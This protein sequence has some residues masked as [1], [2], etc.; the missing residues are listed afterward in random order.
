MMLACEEGRKGRGRP[1]KGWIRG[2][3]GGNGD[4]AEGSGEEPERV[5]EAD[6]DSR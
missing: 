4:R 2:D 3:S 5:E 1:R 6:Y